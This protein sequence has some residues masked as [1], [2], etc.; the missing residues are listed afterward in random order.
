[1]IL[2]SD[3]RFPFAQAGRIRRREDDQAIEPML[4]GCALIPRPARA[5]NRQIELCRLGKQ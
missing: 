2:S 5:L 1:M 3:A 4:D